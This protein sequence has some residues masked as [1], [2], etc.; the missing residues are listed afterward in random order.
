[1]IFGHA[2]VILPAVTTIQVPYRSFFYV[3]LAL[4]HLSLTMRVVGD[5]AGIESLRVHGG[6]VNAAAIVLFVLATISS[7][8]AAR[9]SRA[10]AATAPAA[11]RR[12]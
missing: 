5:L 1:M 11:G 9:L 7:A 3:H 4:L 2:P 12:R 8:A 6:H 10:R